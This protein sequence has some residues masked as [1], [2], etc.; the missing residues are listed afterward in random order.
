MG[1]PKGK[2]KPNGSPGTPGAKGK[3]SPYKTK[4]S[5][6]KRA[7]I[8]FDE[9]AATSGN[10]QRSP[11]SSPRKKGRKLANKTPPPSD[12]KNINSNSTAINTEIPPY[13]TR[14]KRKLGGTTT[15][16]LAR[17][18]ELVEKERR[19]GSAITR[20]QKQKTDNI[21]NSIVDESSDGELNIVTQVSGDLDEDGALQ[22]EDSSDEETHDRSNRIPARRVVERDFAAEAAAKNS[23]NEDGLLMDE[24]ERNPEL[25]NMVQRMVNKAK[26]GKETETV[27]GIQAKNI[28]RQLPNLLVPPPQPKSASD[29]TIY[30]PA[31]KRQRIEKSQNSPKT[32]PGISEDM[33][34]KISN[35]IE[36]IRLEASEG[37]QS[38]CGFRGR[39]ATTRG[40]VSGR[41]S[42]SSG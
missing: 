23:S 36:R 40:V 9:M 7:N 30:T 39:R 16:D 26:G 2:T 41:T 6:G 15:A 22:A 35:Y 13:G 32:G 20:Q 1:K 3:I 14:S 5:G 17:V 12:G 42:C 37:K 29:T 10:G 25:W 27:S 18:L 28:G 21:N 33:F 34:D 19:T 8:K 4:L 38:S 24:I 31:L 11:T